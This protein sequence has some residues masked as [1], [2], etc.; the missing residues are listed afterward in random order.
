MS[1]KPRATA[2]TV[3]FPRRLSAIY[4]NN[5]VKRTSY[6]IRF[7]ILDSERSEG[8]YSFTMMIVEFV[9]KNFF[10]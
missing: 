6:R 4:W 5:T 9:C 10:F 8:F 7:S 1:K 3:C 2:M